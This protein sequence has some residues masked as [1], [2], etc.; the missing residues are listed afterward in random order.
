MNL[1]D[2]AFLE[3]FRDN[4]AVLATAFVCLLFAFSAPAF[5]LPFLYA[6]VIEEFGWSRE[7]AALLA[8]AKYAAGAVAAVL[9]GRFVDI[10]G[11]RL[12][13]IVLMVLGGIAMLSFLWVPH[14]A[15]YYLVGVL[16]GVSGTGLIV[17]VKALVARYFH[18]SQG[19]AMGAVMLATSLG[20]A[21]VPVLV[22][23]L[24]AEYGWR[25]AT[26]IMS[27]GTWFVALPLLLFG[28]GKA[29]FEPDAEPPSK[30]QK[31]PLAGVLLALAGQP[32]FW[33]VGLALFSAAVVDQA[34]IQHQVM[35][36][37][38]DLGFAA[39]YVAAGVSLMGLIGV[40]ARPL[41]GAI[42]D[43]FSARG[44]ST[45]YL[46][47]AGASLVA[48]AI[49][50]P[51]LFAAFVVLRAVG[52]AAVLLDSAVLSKHVFGLENIGL[53]LGVYTAFVAVGFAL[54]PWMMGRLYGLSGSYLLPFTICAVLAV[55][56][57]LV[58]LPV[59]PQHWLEQRRLRQS[60][61]RS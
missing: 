14:L 8:S 41:V 18:A 35:Y 16:L 40:I 55:F 61:G 32:R 17:A 10:V 20:A 4:R 11:V 3:E 15:G 34:F 49:T 60:T 56:A 50:N 36:L 28:I 21:A 31:I 39:G 6:P 38:L 51:A 25:A 46:S 13:L 23:P 29:P 45:L 33:L 44:V 57:A 2:A 42:F 53:L 59:R 52:H 1:K 37:Q 26:A 27:C 22:T 24:I 30:A 9:V 7:Q 5:I 48:V 19:T 54:G 43:R 47:L 12:G 58:L